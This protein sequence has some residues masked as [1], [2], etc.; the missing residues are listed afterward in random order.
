MSEPL[1]GLDGPRTEEE[2][3]RW[4]AAV[5]EKARRYQE[6]QRQV[7]AVSVT[8][9][10]RDGAVRVTVDSS[11]VVT[12]LVISDAVRTMSGAQISALVLSTMRRAQARIS[13]RI[14]EVATATVGDDPETVDAMVTTYRERFPEPEPEPDDRPRSPVTEIRFGEEDEEEGNR[15]RRP[16]PSRRPPED[17]DP[18][19]YSYLR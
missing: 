17:D 9:T 19:D 10:S 11:G 7:A 13:D 4:A 2:L 14:A 8:E 16:A 3:R 5:E 6:M 18:D 15:P 12:D 1:F